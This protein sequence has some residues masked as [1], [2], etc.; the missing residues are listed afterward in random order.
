MEQKLQVIVAA[1]VAFLIGVGTFGG[2]HAL[3]QVLVPPPPALP[4]SQSES[5]LQQVINNQI[6][7]IQMLV[8]IQNALASIQQAQRNRDIQ[9]IS[10]L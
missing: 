2:V 7:E 6:I 3:A 5:G 4:A 1:G 10:P 9:S 8:K